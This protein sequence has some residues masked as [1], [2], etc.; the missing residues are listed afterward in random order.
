VGHDTQLGPEAVLHFGRLGLLAQN[1]L[2]PFDAGRD[3]ILL[4]EGAA[5]VV[6]EKADEATVRGATVWGEFL[7]YGCASEAAGLMGIRA[8]GEGVVDAVRLALEDAGLEPASV[9][10][11]V[12]HGNGT[13][14]SDASEAAAI[15]RVFGVSPPPVTGFKWA[16][17]HLMA[18]SG[19]IDMVLALAALRHKT[20]PGIATLRM[21]DPAFP[22][23]PVSATAQTPMTD[24]ALVI[25]RGFAGMNVAL[26]VRGIA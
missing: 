12:A 3:G 4:G 16:F 19:A 17:G 8:D 13:S 9:G 14:Q 18:A 2:R 10:M 5:S 6:L 26:L 15:R 25:N 22:S 11:I 24:I 23:L 20:V 7:G 1:E 21:L